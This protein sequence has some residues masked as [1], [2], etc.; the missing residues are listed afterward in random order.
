MA[1]GRQRMTGK[2]K[3]LM[4]LMAP[5]RWMEELLRALV[6]LKA[7]EICLVAVTMKEA[8]LMAFARQKEPKTQKEM[9]MMMRV[10]HLA[11]MKLMVVTI[12]M[13]VICWGQ[14]DRR[15]LRCRWSY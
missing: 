8:K 12:G 7:V 13:D 2:G 6:T 4:K 3:G 15:C 9:M 1:S 11:Q 5:V 10:A 14:R